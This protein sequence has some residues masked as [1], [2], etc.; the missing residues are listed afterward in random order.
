MF[1][2]TLTNSSQTNHG[3]QTQRKEVGGGIQISA[4]SHSPNGEKRFICQ[5][6]RRVTAEIWCD[7]RNFGGKH[8]GI[9]TTD[10]P[11]VRSARTHARTHTDIHKHPP[12]LEPEHP[13]LSALIEDLK[14]VTTEVKVDKPER[15]QWALEGSHGGGR[16]LSKKRDM[17][18]TG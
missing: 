15:M 11:A 5:V 18:S 13:M 6:I 3:H 14:I 17:D 1:L 12:L 16:A 10:A 7:G 2:I 4:V 9:L 8:I